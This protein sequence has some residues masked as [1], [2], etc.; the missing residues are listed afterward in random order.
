MA[1]V[2]IPLT[3]PSSTS[4][5]MR[6]RRRADR[7]PDYTAARAFARIGWPKLWP[8]LY[9]YATG[10][11]GLPAIGAKT[12]RPRRGGRAREHAGS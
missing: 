8:T 1:A 11:L 3:I 7:R 6:T 9:L 5:P 4:P 10:T 2:L 12:R